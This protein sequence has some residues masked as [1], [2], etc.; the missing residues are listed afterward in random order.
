MTTTSAPRR[1]FSTT[2]PR[3]LRR[4]LPPMRLWQKAKSLG[5]WDPSAIDLAPDR[6]D[7]QRLPDGEKDLLLR[8][9]SNFL[10]GEESVTLELL[11]LILVVASEG[12][13]E[14]EMFLT[15]FLWEEAKHVDTF[16]RFLDEVAHE[17]GDLARYH[18]PSYGRIFHEELPAAMSRLRTDTSPAAQA[19][20]A[21]TYHLIV[22][23]VL[24]ETGYHTYY[25]MLQGNG[26]MPGMQELVGLIKRDES[27]HLAYGVYLLSRLLA[28]HGD[29]VWQ[30]IEGRMGELIGPA[31]A[32]VDEA[33]AAYEVVPF[34]L[35]PE[36]FAA[37][38]MA[39]FQKR[40]E[41]IAKARGLTLEQVE[42]WTDLGEAAE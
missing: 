6:R 35:R 16:R 26:L 29:A 23:G 33:F 28:E 11:P 24:A 7:W 39:Q 31:I 27:R 18:T 17:H 36:D 32:L 41:R 2:S 42:R 37:Y 19:R 30:A 12:R 4:E 34:G 3:G 15:A 25:A 1:A 38:A 22:E 14:E 13:I 10:A 20:A 8:L 9:T 21:V 40:M 5:T